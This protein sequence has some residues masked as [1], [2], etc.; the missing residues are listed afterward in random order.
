MEKKNLNELFN[1]ITIIPLCI[2]LLLN[3]N[4]IFRELENFNFILIL[5]LS[6]IIK[7]RR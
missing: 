7:R 1:L 3:K 5:Y 2:K 6:Y 4:L